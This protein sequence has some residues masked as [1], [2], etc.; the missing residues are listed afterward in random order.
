MLHA[1]QHVHL[2]TQ[3]CT[4]GILIVQSV[5]GWGPERGV[6]M[7]ADDV[8]SEASESIKQGEVEF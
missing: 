4:A 5:H 3:W 1:S 8:C 2:I 7:Y 6:T